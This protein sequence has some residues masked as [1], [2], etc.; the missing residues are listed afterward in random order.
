MIYYCDIS[1]LEWVVQKKKQS[2]PHPL[3]KFLP[4]REGGG[5]NCLEKLQ[6]FVV[7]VEEAGCIFNSSVRIWWIFLEEPNVFCLNS[8][9]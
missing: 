5:H 1:A 2:I 7:N 9:C 4:A 6:T 3:R 8:L